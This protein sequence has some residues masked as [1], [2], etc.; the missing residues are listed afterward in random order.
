MGTAPPGASQLGQV[1]APPV[2]RL[3]EL[4]LSQSDNVL[5]E[6][7][8]RQVAL[9]AG[10]PASFDGA[11][12]AVRSTLEQAGFDVSG[13]VLVDG[14]GLSTRNRLSPALL[15]AILAAAAGEPAT[16]GRALLAGLAVAGYDGTLTERFGDGPA[17]GV[18]RAKT[19]TLDG[20]SA[21]A[22]VLQT[23]DGRL[24]VFALMADEV[25]VG[26]RYPA[27]AALDE[28]ATLVAGCGCSR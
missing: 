22:G 10:R 8:A 27:E 20:V 3:V 14:S 1:S 26:G 13:T 24:L 18:V 2:D 23:A 19:G 11:A 9:A 4:M 6:T 15:S 16:P 17:D 7:L 25:P 5:A 21:L 28:L 12:A